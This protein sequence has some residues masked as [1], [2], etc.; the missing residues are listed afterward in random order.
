LHHAIQ[1][2]R[3]GVLS[4]G[5]VMLYDNARSH[6]AAVTE[7]VITTFGWEQF[8]HPPYSPDLVPSD[9]HVFL[10]LKTFL[11][12]QWVHIDTKVKEAINT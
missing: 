4:W 8:Y 3:H 11:G 6:I 7:G 12:C 10:H 1:N 9:F 5:V 2:K